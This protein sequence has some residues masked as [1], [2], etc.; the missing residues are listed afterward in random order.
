MEW[1]GSLVS[2]QTVRAEDRV[3]KTLGIL[4]E[5]DDHD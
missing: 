2:L 4:P 3:T 5:D 1:C